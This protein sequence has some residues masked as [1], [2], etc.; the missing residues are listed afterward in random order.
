MVLYT[1]REEE[2]KTALAASIKVSTP[3][4]KLVYNISAE[5]VDLR[6][7]LGAKDGVTRSIVE[8]SSASLGPS[9][10]SFVVNICGGLNNSVNIAS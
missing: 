7:R 2:M 4:S 9:L 3:L 8:D 6:K 5:V 10:L 1:V